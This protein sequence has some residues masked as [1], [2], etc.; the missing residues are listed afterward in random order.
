MIELLR[1]ARVKP[2][3]LVSAALL[4]ASTIRISFKR[5]SVESGLEES[6]E[7]CDVLIADLE[8]RVAEA[9]T[10]LRVLLE[11]LDLTAK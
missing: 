2:A 8:K 1:Y 6:P 11:L 7:I 10:E 5:F 4:D 3:G 9:N